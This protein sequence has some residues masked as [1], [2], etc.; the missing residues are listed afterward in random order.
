MAKLRYTKIA[1]S[2]TRL[3]TVNAFAKLILESMDARK[4]TMTNF[5]QIRPIGEAKSNRL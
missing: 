2:S 5:Y 1:Q 3:K 4:H